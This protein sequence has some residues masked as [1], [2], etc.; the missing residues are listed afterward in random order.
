MNMQIVKKYLGLVWM[1]LAPVLVVFLL[2]QAIEKTG[3]AT[4]ATKANTL[5]QWSI[6]LLIF[7]PVCIGL[8]VFGWYA[9]QDE[10]RDIAE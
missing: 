10:Y 5:L 9:W 8:F 1:L 6:I 7:L 2:A 3:L 4:V